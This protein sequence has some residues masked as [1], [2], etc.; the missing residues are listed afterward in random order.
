M[1]G[2]D[3]IA[4]LEEGLVLRFSTLIVC[5]VMVLEERRKIYFWK[6]CDAHGNEDRMVE[7]RQNVG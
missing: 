4:V 6:K 5:G 2:Q 3:K 7:V 1:N